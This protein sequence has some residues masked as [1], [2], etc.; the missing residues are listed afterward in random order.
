MRGFFAIGIE[1][2]KTS[3][4]IGTLFR[5][6]DL[7]DAAFIFTVGRRYKRQPSDVLKSWRHMPLFNFTDLNDLYS[8]LPYGCMLVGVEMKPEAIS[9]NSY[10]HPQRACY[11]LG[12]EDNG[13]SSEAQKRCNQL[14]VLPGRRSL[15]VSVAGSIVIFD[16]WSK[17]QSTDP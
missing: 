15:N 5:S 8:H 7:F 3:Y 4:N 9:I 14:V 13:L 10:K 2:G 1:N 16:R 11:L 17:G 12:A 6:A